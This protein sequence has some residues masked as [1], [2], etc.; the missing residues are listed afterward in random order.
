MSYNFCPCDN[1]ICIAICRHK[2]WDRMRFECKLM[3][4]YI[5]RFMSVHHGAYK[6]AIVDI[7]KPTQWTVDENYC[8]IQ[9][10]RY[11]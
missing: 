6:K 3:E 7:L 8:L 4:N 10:K 5:I 11:F 2:T 9:R 1:C